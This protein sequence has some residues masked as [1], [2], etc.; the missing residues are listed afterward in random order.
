MLQTWQHK[1][2]VLC[3]V[4]SNNLLYFRLLSRCAS[5]RISLELVRWRIDSCKSHSVLLRSMVADLQSCGQHGSH[6]DL[7]TTSFRASSSNLPR[8]CG[9]SNPPKEEKKSYSIMLLVTLW[10]WFVDVVRRN[11]KRSL[12]FFE[13]S[14]RSYFQWDDQDVMIFIDRIVKGQFSWYFINIMSVEKRKFYCVCKTLAE[15]NARMYWTRSVGRSSF[16][17]ESTTPLFE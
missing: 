16:N 13:S 2:S 1:S 11:S 4:R 6:W 12:N 17:P 9:N 10:T 14:Y 15:S 7:S 5:Q 3:T 8:L